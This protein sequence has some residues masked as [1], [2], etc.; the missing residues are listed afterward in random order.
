MGDFEGPKDPMEPLDLPVAPYPGFTDKVKQ[1]YEEDVD[2][3]TENARKIDGFIDRVRTKF[4]NDP[5]FAA[6]VVLVTVFVIHNFKGPIRNA[7]RGK[8]KY[9]KDIVFDEPY[10][11]VK[12]NNKTEDKWD[13][14]D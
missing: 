14:M 6:G 3:L 9:V 10:L 13:I 5:K 8:R 2:R 12:F 7:L 4:N 1:G 11:L